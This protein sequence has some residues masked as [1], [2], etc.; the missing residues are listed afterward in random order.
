M[1]VLLIDDDDGNRLLVRQ[2]LEQRFGATVTGAKN[3]V[4]AL[5]VLERL[6]PDL[7]FLDLW[8]PV[9]NGHDFLE[10]MRGVK[11]WKD[12]PVIVMTAM[13]DKH[14]VQKLL[15]MRISGYMV[16]PV[17]MEQL[18]DHVTRICAVLPVN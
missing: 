10:R 17:T 18:T 12:I 6:V 8:M 11:E 14:V 13:Q 7:I 15:Q 9:L 16:K 3:G 5:R 2:G 4:E 1:Q